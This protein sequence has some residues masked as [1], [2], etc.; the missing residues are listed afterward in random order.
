MRTA[1]LSFADLD[2]GLLLTSAPDAT[3][4]FLVNNFIFL[5]SALKKFFTILSSKE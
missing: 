5:A 1:T 3:T 2:L 4:G